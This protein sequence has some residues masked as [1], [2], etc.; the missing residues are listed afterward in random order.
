MKRASGRIDVTRDIIESG[1]LAIFPPSLEGM[2]TYLMYLAWRAGSQPGEEN[3][4]K[5]FAKQKTAAE[6]LGCSRETISRRNT[7]L[8]KLSILKTQPH[9]SG[10]PLLDTEIAD[11]STLCEIAK[12]LGKDGAP[13]MNEDNSFRNSRLAKGARVTRGSHR[14]P[15]DTGLTRLSDA[16]I[17][18]TG[19]AGTTPASDTGITPEVEREPSRESSQMN[20]VSSL[21][22]P[23]ENLH[24][25]GSSSHTQPQIDTAATEVWNKVSRELSLQLPTETYEWW[26]RDTRAE[27]IEDGALI[28]SAPNEYACA[29]LKNRL[30]KIIKELLPEGLTPLFVDRRTQEQPQSPTQ[31][32][33]RPP[34]DN[35]VQ[36]KTPEKRN[37]NRRRN[38]NPGTIPNGQH[39]PNPR[40]T[41]DR[42][43]KEPSSFDR[44]R[45][46]HIDYRQASI[47]NREGPPAKP[48]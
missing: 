21:G 41:S 38:A 17:T 2:K 3:Y 8:C 44:A 29:F 30:A 35:P 24:G 25:N 11:Y 32:R 12:K 15:S 48:Q 9:T 16:R 13:P 34:P 19:D 10:R 39:S 28:V 1:I 33:P 27:R 20:H 7:Y 43:P 45:T 40:Q 42:T 36:A 31:D 6:Q 47:R 14:Q 22:N 4:R 37:V 18:H 46:E 5:S 26:V 23:K